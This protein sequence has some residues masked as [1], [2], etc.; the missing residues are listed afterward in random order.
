[1]PSLRRETDYALHFLR[2]LSKKRD[3][4][5]SLKTISIETG[6]SYLFLQKI[7]RKLRQAGIIESGAGVN[8]GY[9]LEIEPRKLSLNKIISAIEGPCALWRCCGKKGCAGSA[10]CPQSKKVQKINKKVEKVLE[11][12]KLT[13]I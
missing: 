1:M 10:T 12:V 7:A 8:G 5:V 9:R 13:D 11:G 4:F 3:D 6:V 2:A